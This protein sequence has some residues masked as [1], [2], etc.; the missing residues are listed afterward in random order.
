MQ[1]HRD[2]AAKQRLEKFR[3][4]MAK[5]KQEAEGSVETPKTPKTKGVSFAASVEDAME[6]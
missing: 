2:L 4:T 3:A 6:E 1:E 5:K